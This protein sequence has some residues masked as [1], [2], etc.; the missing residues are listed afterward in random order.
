[1]GTAI[2]SISKSSGSDISADDARAIA[3]EAF[4]YGFPM[5]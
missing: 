5:A 4:I 3:K 2:S 1:M